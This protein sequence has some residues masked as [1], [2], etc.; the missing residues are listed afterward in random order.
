MIA[1]RT[2]YLVRHGETDW[3]A[4][5][6]FQGSIDIPLNARGFAQASRN[7]QTLRG[8][9]KDPSVYAYHVSPLTRSRE[10]LTRILAELGLD[11]QPVSIDQRLRE[12]S[13]GTWEG[14][15]LAELEAEK[16][17][18][19]A[20]RYQDKW[21]FRPESGESYHDLTLRTKEWLDETLAST[22]K[23][24]VIVAHGGVNRA[25]RGLLLSICHCDVPELDSLQDRVYCIKQGTGFWI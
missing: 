20:A 23:D 9:M 16:P 3:N 6:R 4:E 18:E 10:T 22:D 1:D 11:T 21:G 8:E 15:T 14:R 24:L 25:L 5:G 17:E 13:F 2:F 7:G 12:I 19:V